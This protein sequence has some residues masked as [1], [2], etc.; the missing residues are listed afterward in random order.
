MVH[1]Y[2][3]KGLS[4]NSWHVSWKFLMQFL[5]PNWSSDTALQVTCMVRWHMLFHVGLSSFRMPCHLFPPMLPVCFSFLTH[6]SLLVSHP[7]TR[8]KCV[9]GQVANLISD[10]CHH[11]IKLTLLCTS[12]ESQ[13][14]HWRRGCGK[15]HSHLPID[16]KK[17]AAALCFLESWAKLHM[18]LVHWQVLVPNDY[19]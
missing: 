14:S 8:H 2:L 10:R 11:P 17:R 18:R 4:K 13:V 7:L 6:S 19:P 9:Y 1:Y 3:L 12:Y 5:A 16:K 15:C